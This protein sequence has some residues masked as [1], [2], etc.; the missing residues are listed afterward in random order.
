MCA[1]CLSV[2]VPG[3]A[4]VF[5]CVC[6]CVYLYLCVYLRELCVR[7]C[8]HH[9]LMFCKCQRSRPH[10]TGVRPRRCVPHHSACYTGG[11]VPHRPRHP[12]AVGGDASHCQRRPLGLRATVWVPAD[13]GEVLPSAGLDHGGVSAFPA[14]DLAAGTAL[15]TFCSIPS[16]C[17][18]PFQDNTCFE[19]SA[20]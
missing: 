17:I 6:T 12:A 19:P 4:C 14:L 3:C 5:I 15:V 16:F 20:R 8:A 7:A 1:L 18:T 9:S 13:V 2:C 10:V 11:H